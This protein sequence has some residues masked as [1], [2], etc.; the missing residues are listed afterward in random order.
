VTIYDYIIGKYLVYPLN[1]FLFLTCP[2]SRGYASFIDNFLIYGYIKTSSMLKSKAIQ[3]LYVYK[4]LSFKANIPVKIL[5]I[6]RLRC[7]EV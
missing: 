6:V 3:V 5:S 7:L 2:P 4:V 1:N